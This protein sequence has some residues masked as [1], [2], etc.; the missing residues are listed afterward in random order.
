MDSAPVTLTRRGSIAV[1]T[2][3]R[4]DRMNALSRD[5]LLSIGRHAREL[6]MDGDVRAIVLT[7]FE[8]DEIREELDVLGVDAFLCKPQPL[9]TIAR[10]IDELAAPN[11]GYSIR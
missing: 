11:E 3:N 10:L 5:M 7:A 2:L 1:L 8:S 4:P 9:E 6:A